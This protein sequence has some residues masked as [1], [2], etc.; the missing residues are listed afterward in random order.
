MK[1]I[2]LVGLLGLIAVAAM[3]VAERVVDNIQTADAGS[4]PL[5]DRVPMPERELETT[6]DL[7]HDLQLHG[8]TQQGDEDEVMRTRR[9]RKAVLRRRRTTGHHVHT[10]VPWGRRRRTGQPPNTCTADTG[11]TCRFV[12]C[13]T[14]RGARCIDSKCVCDTGKCAIHGKCVSTAPV[15][16]DSAVTQEGADKKEEDIDLSP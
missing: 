10:H 2:V 4:E 13:N 3:P 6:Q 11:G 12:Q 14:S 5:N 7:D 16:D 8:Q 1:S 9:R 15:S